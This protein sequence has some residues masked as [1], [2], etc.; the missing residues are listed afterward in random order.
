[1]V[2]IRHQTIGVT[3][4]LLLKELVLEQ[5]Q[6]SL[7]IRVVDIDVLL[8]VAPRCEIIARTWKF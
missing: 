2:V 8:R 3:L 5:L 6:K 4:P 7:P 1:M